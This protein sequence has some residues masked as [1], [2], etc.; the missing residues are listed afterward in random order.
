MKLVTVVS[1]DGVLVAQQ[2]VPDNSAR[3]YVSKR[4]YTWLLSNPTMMSCLC[5]CCGML[6]RRD[7]LDANGVCVAGV[8]CGSDVD[9][10]TAFRPLDADRALRGRERANVIWQAFR[11][12]VQRDMQFNPGTPGEA[13]AW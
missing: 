8:G 10:D 3:I 9:R 4:A 2:C 11:E 13:E 1:G 12:T 6:V 7:E 5:K